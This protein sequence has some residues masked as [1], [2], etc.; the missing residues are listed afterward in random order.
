MT[1]GSALAIAAL[2]LVTA[3]APPGICSCWLLR[4]AAHI[5]PHVI[6]PGSGEHPH[7]DMFELFGARADA[8]VTTA[9]TP[10]AVLLA[11]LSA[12]PPWRR[13]GASAWVYPQWSPEP[14]HPPP[15]ISA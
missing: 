11:S 4:D 14:T 1:L 2:V 10:V 3:L 13:A 5:H 9:L 7:D 12:A 6:D 8:R 15:R